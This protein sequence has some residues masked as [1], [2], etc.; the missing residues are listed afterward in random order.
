MEAVGEGGKQVVEDVDPKK[1]IELDKQRVD[2]VVECAEFVVASPNVKAV[3]A[4]PFVIAWTKNKGKY[5]VG[6][7]SFH[8]NDLLFQ[9]TQ[10]LRNMK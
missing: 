4:E 7:V 5:V 8:G 1:S 6:N 10:M 9:Y 2:M 3:S